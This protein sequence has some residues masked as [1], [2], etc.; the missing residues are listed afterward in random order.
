MTNETNRKQGEQTRIAET[1]NKQMATTHDENAAQPLTFT[2][3]KGASRSTWF[4]GVLVILIVGWMGSGF[5]LP[6]EN[7]DPVSVREETKLVAVA[8]T[9]STAETVTQ[10]YQAEGQ[11]LPD[12]E[13]MMRSETSG[14]VAEVLVAKG[15]DVE[16]G[17]IIARFDPTA[18]LADANRATQELARAQREFDNAEALLDRGVATA[19]RVSQARAA[20]AGAQSELADVQQAADALTILAPFAGRVE[21]LDID[22]GEFVSAGMEVGRLVDIT[23]LTVAIQVPQQS[24]NR[25]S[26][27]QP[28]TV[29][30]ITGEERQGTVTFVG[31]SAASETRTFLAEIEVNNDDR[32]IPAGISAEVIIPTGETIAHFLSASIVSLN[33][34]GTLGVKTVDVNNV[35]A[36]FPIQVVKAQIDGIWVTGLPDTVDVITVGQ[37][38]V[39]E[40]ETVAPAAGEQ[41]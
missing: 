33:T 18:N 12:R 29:R 16:A 8:V 30:F 1:E 5:I 37:G 40:N 36:F 27:G 39:N 11:A 14:D 10:F 15:Q 35:V 22:E 24:L 3:D 13:T 6:S 23:P 7:N 32:A 20:L 34:E 38:Y 9:T 19:D 17:A 41:G 28:A 4:A 21:T 25:L 2:S 31:T 26:V